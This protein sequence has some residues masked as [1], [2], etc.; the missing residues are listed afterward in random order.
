MEKQTTWLYKPMMVEPRSFELLSLYSGKQANFK[1]LKHSTT[2]P[3]G[4]AI[5]LIYGGNPELLMV[6]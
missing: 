5:V 6:F 1:N 3:K 2:N 4:I